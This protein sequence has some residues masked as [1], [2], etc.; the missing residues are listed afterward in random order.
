VRAAWVALRT[1]SRET[2]PVLRRRSELLSRKDSFKENARKEVIAMRRE[3]KD[4]LDHDYGAI[5]SLRE[6]LA[7]YDTTHYFEFSDVIDSTKRLLQRQME[8]IVQFLE[9][10]RIDTSSLREQ[11]ARIYQNINYTAGD[12]YTVGAVHG[13]TNII[14]SHGAVNNVGPPAEHGGQSPHRAPA[15]RAQ[16]GPR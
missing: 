1:A 7:A 5:V 6:A 13:G 10:H 3:L 2:I 9:D 4:G 12:S 15:G 8:C 11:A 14:G 16:G